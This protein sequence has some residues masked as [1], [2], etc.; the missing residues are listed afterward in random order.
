MLWI[1]FVSYII[2]GIPATYLLGFVCHLGIYGII[3]S[4]SA[5]LFPAGA[6]FLTYFLKSTKWNQSP[7]STK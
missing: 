5:S 2:I 7:V 4:F 3:L 6:L 1:A